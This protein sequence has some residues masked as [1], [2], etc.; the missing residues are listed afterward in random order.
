MISYLRSQYRQK[1]TGIIFKTVQLK[2]HVIFLGRLANKACLNVL[3]STKSFSLLNEIWYVCRGRWVWCR[4]RV[5]LSK[6]NVK[7]KVK[8]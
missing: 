2:S 4:W 8:V 7:V 6:I 1:S 3:T 5:T